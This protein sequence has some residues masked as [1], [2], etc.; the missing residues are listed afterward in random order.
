[1]ILLDLFCGAGGAAMGYYRAGFRTIVGVDIAPQPHYP[2]LFVQ[3]NALDYLKQYGHNYDVIHAS[4]PC[5]Q[6]S[7]L[8][9]IWRSR[10]GEHAWSMKHPDLIGVTRDALRLTGKPYVI[11]NVPDAPLLNPVV[12]CGTFFGLKVY[13]HRAFECSFFLLTPPHSPHHDNCA[14]VG[15]GVSRKGFISISGQGGFG[16]S[17]GLAYARQAIGIDWTT[18]SELSQAIPPAYTE[19]IGRQLLKK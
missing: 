8:G 5:Q 19:F 10:I 4:P 2:F 18:R 17:G 3:D 16:F 9:A 12:L 11:E 13:R 14:A 15:R 1:M 7:R 6:F